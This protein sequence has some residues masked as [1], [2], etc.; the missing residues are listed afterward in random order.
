L[1]YAYFVTCT[2]VVKDAAGEIVELR[3]RYDPE[4]RGGDAPNGRRVKATL[5]WVSAKHAL[6]AEMRLY[7][8]LWLVEDPADVP[9][10]GDFVAN[11]NPNSLE[12]I[13]DARVE[14]SLGEA[15]AGSRIQF[16]RQGYFCVDPDT[17][18]GRLVF[19]RTVTLRDTWAKLSRDAD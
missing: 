1:R 15:E 18:H 16:E 8:R 19:N 11:L 4:T 14:P 12:V 7:D 10:G 17:K 6:V 13:G 9:E 2:G 5:H 3:C